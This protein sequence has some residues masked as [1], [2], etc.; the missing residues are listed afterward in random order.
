[1]L[2]NTEKA[3]GDNQ[4]GQLRSEITRCWLFSCF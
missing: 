1:L 2:S 4:F 3:A